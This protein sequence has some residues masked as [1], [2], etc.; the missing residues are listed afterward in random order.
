MKTLITLL[1]ASVGIASAQTNTNSA[2]IF[3]SFTNTVGEYI[4]NAQ[5]VSLAPNKLV[6]RAADGL[7][8]GTIRLEKLPPELQA[9]LNYDPDEANKADQID[10]DRKAADREKQAIAQFQANEQARRDEAYQK[11]LKHRVY[12]TGKIIQKIDDGLLLSC[13]VDDG[14]MTILLRNHPRYDVL[15]AQ[16]EVQIYGFPLG[17]YSY[18][19][20]NNSKNTIHDWTCDTN[21]AISYYLLNN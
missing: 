3:I 10:N 6:Y 1:L 2:P 19:T 9:K 14:Y 13:P 20:V 17:T 4:T 11:I 21:I 8:G 5:V 16:D 15:A 12:I 7:G 18:T